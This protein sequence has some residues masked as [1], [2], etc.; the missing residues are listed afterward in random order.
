VLE[1]CGESANKTTTR[2]TDTGTRVNNTEWT[3]NNVQRFVRQDNF[4]IQTRVKIED[5][6]RIFLT[7]TPTLNHDDTG[8]AAHNMQSACKVG[9]TVQQEKALLFCLLELHFFPTSF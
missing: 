8:N 6:R 7:F 3:F 4:A 9:L 2:Q 5:H 1:V